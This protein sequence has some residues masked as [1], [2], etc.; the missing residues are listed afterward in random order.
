MKPFHGTSIEIQVGD[1]TTLFVANYPPEA[2]EEYMI[3]LFKP[4]RKSTFFPFP[5]C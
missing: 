3:N 2:D 1:G 4:V 5:N